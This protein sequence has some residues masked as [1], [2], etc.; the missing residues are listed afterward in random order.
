MLTS[1]LFAGDPLL[2]A[3]AQDQDRI[4]RSQHRTDPAVRKVQ[5]ALLD[6]DPDSLPQFGA[7]GDY[8]DETAG[9]V[10][11]FKAEVLGVPRPRSSTT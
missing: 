7:D 6:W 10:A 8:G 2:E 4:S 3:I 1:A 9:A 11:R 5:T